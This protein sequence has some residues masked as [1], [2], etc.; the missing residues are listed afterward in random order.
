MLQLGVLSCFRVLAALLGSVLLELRFGPFLGF[1]LAVEFAL[2]GLGQFFLFFLLLG[3]LLT[4]SLV[5]AL[6]LSQESQQ[7]EVFVLQHYLLLKQ[8][9][10]REPRLLTN[11]L[12]AAVNLL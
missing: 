2:F 1:L 4:G 11:G 10:R 9:L 7:V 3:R 5:G 12:G 6:L 8:A